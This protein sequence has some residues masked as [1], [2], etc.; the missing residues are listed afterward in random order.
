MAG[1]YPF[2]VE[3]K[4]TRL[5]PWPWPWPRPRPR[6]I[7][8]NETRA[9]AINDIYIIRKLIDLKAVMFHS[10]PFLIIPPE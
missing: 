4:A 6:R 7:E 3:L 2:L 9:L 1:H 8:G 5:E 10:I